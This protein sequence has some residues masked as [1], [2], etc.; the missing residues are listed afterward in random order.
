MDNVAYEQWYENFWGISTPGH[1]MTPPEPL[2]L[3]HDY[4]SP[5]YYL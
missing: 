2:N 5:S 1:F 3:S 4:Q